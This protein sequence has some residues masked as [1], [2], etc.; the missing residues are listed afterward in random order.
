V[1]LAARAPVVLVGGCGVGGCIDAHALNSAFFA[2]AHVPVLGLV[3]N[4]GALDGFY[5]YEEC[6]VSLEAWFAATRPREQLFG[7]VPEAP[8]L[9]G[10]REQVPTMAPGQVTETTSLSSP[11][12][13][14]C[15][16]VSPLAFVFLSNHMSLSRLRAHPQAL[17]AAE[18]NIGHIAGHVDVA[19]LI[20]AA[21]ADPWNRNR[22]PRLATATGISPLQLLPTAPLARSLPTG[23]GSTFSRA[24]I[25]AAAAA[26]GA[27]GG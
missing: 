7:V 4:R 18:A 10:A 24:A 27:K 12:P 26:Q 19:S 16:A 22:R 13:L 17:A 23:T 25:E 5:R 3:A 6:A 8:Q 15:L 9:D 1:A 20:L 14:P 11:S 21:A 2:A